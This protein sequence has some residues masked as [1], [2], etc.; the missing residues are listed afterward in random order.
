MISALLLAATLAAAPPPETFV[1]PSGDGSATTLGVR[2]AES[3]PT[4]RVSFAIRQGDGSR[5]PESVRVTVREAGG[6][7]RWSID[8]PPRLAAKPHALLMPRGHRYE[9][10]FAAAHHRPSAAV[11]DAATDAAL[12]TRT[13]SRLPAIAGIVRTASGSPLAGATI[14]AEGIGLLAKSDGSGA[15]ALEIEDRWPE[16]LQIAYPGLTT[17]VVPLPRAAADTVLPPATLVKGGTLEL[18]VERKEDGELA[19]DLL[20]DDDVLRRGTIAAGASSI[21]FEDLDGGSYTALVRGKEPLQ[22]LAV[23]VRCEAGATNRRKVRIDPLPVTVRVTRGEQPVAGER[24]ELQ[25]KADRWSATIHTGVDGRWSS[26]AW[27]RGSYLCAAGGDDAAAP[28]I[29]FAS[30]GG[31]D[32][33]EVSIELPERSIAGTVKDAATGDP[34]PNARVQ[35]DST[36]AD[37]TGS[38]LAVTSDAAGLF[39]FDAVHAGSHTV[40]V[41]AE[42]YLTSPQS[43]FELGESE[44]TH[45]L[46]IALTRGI[47]RTIRVVNRANVPLAGATVISA[48][49]GTVD[50]ILS[51]DGEGRAEVRAREG[52]E[53]VVYVIP[54]EGSFAVTR[55]RGVRGDDGESRIVVPDGNASLEIRTSD[56]DGHPIPNVRF[57]LRYEGELIP[58]DVAMRLERLAGLS[59]HT[60]ATGVALL[61]RVPPGFFELW[62]LRTRA[63]AEAILASLGPTAPVQVA[64][65]P[66]A[67]VA[68]MTFARRR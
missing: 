30:L 23:S 51:T 2:G 32:A 49:D 55:I 62:P 42:Q 57:L 44:T 33:A 21:T 28:Y 17:R 58:P 26:E 22:Q 29:T 11:I 63:E 35:L 12:G 24:V 34:V 36:N 38:S 48:A 15:F 54:R 4:A 56:V 66:G 46:T 68:A 8:L 65:K 7:R 53:A 18:A 9:L 52:R 50:Q 13:L 10:A 16:R 6:G 27:Q 37:G 14:T 3:A 47:G 25:N 59:A 31:N 43:T 19:V 60:D 67:N 5:F 20:R 1:A 40:Y 45:V 61:D 64:V 39:R 41:R